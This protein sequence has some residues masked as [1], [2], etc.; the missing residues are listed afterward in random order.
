M[1]YIDEYKRV[2]ENQQQRKG[3]AK[4]IPQDRR[5]SS[6]TDTTIIGPKETLFGNQ[7]LLLP[8]WLAQCSGK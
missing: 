7:G 8:K 5:I 6:R 2:K 3:K 4:V 1:D